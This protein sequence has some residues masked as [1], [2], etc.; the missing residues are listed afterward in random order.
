MVLFNY[1]IF[2]Q[3]YLG[4]FLGLLLG[5]LFL[6]LPASPK[7]PKDKL[8]WY[9]LVLCLLSC[10]I[11]IYVGIKYPSLIA[12]VGVL[13]VFKTIMGT[14]FLLMILEGTRR[15]TGWIL[16]VVVLVF[17]LYYKFG[18]LLPGMLQ[19][20]KI[21][22]GRMVA[23]IFLGADAV[24]G[25]ALRTVVMIVFSFILF[26][27]V[28]F[29]TGG[30]KFIFDL[31]TKLMGRYRGGSAK[32]CIIA[33]S[34]FSLLTGSPVADVAATGPLTIPMMKDSGYDSE[35]SGAVCAAAATGACISPPILGAAAFIIAEFLRVPYTEVVL[36]AIVPAVLYYFSLF[37]QSDL[38]AVKNNL[39]G[40]SVEGLPSIIKIV[41]SGWYFVIPLI[42]LVACIFVLHFRPESAA[43]Y[44]M[45]S[46]IVIGLF[47]KESRKNLKRVLHICMTTCRGMFEIAV[48]CGAAGFIVGVMSYSGLGLTL[49]RIITDLAGDS[50]LILAV[51]SA[52]ISIILA[53]GMPVTASYLIMALLVVPAMTQLGVP[54]IAAHMFVFYY[55]AFSF[56]T[57][58]VCVAVIASSSI[59]GS[60]M[61]KTSLQACKLAIPGFVLPFLFVFNP[62]VAL[63][64]SPGE[65]VREIAFAFVAVIAIC[66]GLEGCF[67]AKLNIVLR[68][69]FLVVAAGLFLPTPL[70][71]SIIMVVLF[72]V[73]A[74]VAFIDGGN[75]RT[76]AAA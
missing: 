31:A 30:A 56:I 1:S 52:I 40:L 60:N 15:L 69:L 21:S 24:F 75:K 72:V 68:C 43:F 65:I 35:F 59:A 74:V 18:Y 26:A 6:I 7:L 57:P 48:I 41:I 20:S 19:V 46:I 58:P 37:L 34:L 45:I 38:R 51:T 5:L 29:T 66:V 70:Q 71:V 12:T 76:K 47:I 17:V 67:R 4:I 50:L 33:G 27:Q 16:I 14:L 22:Y 25:V 11:G 49:I 32:T 28:L 9:D 44:A 2:P 36:V 61:L 13:T 10:A 3:Q 39:A 64:G 63:I 23:Q 55:A 42:I 73:L 8:P 54:G 62:P 53:M